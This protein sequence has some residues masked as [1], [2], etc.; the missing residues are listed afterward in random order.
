MFVVVHACVVCRVHC[1]VVCCCVRAVCA[2]T[3][4]LHEARAE[5]IK[6]ARFLLIAMGTSA[7]YVILSYFVPVL[8]F[9]CF[10]RTRGINFVRTSMQVLYNVPV[11]LAVGLPAAHSAGF[12]L[13]ASPALIGE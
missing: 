13:L 5:G 11:M 4:G 10:N 8:C 6:R 7:I 2:A 9:E 1:V 3:A 12:F